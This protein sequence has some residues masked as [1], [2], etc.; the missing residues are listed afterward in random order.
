MTTTNEKLNNDFKRSV[1]FV[2]MVF[3]WDESTIKQLKEMSDP[4]Q[5]KEFVDWLKETTDNM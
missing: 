3:Q 5:K 1:S 2:E 4:N